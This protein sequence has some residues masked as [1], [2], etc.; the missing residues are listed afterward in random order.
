M[1]RLTLLSAIVLL[2]TAWMFAQTS[3][4]QE[5]TS[6]Q[7]GTTTTQSTSPATGESSSN[8]GPKSFTGCLQGSSGNYSL[9]AT[10]GITYQLQGNQNQ[11][12]KHL[13]QE[14][15]VTGTLPASSPAAVAGGTAGASAG[16]SG[17]P[18]SGGTGATSN[19]ASNQ[20]GR[21]PEMSTTSPASAT[22]NAGIIDVKH[23]SKV[24]NTC[25]TGK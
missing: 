1:R 15:T 22:G 9:V 21:H 16:S 18:S 19:P 20:A 12:G 10:N 25:A 4:S 14:V 5:S 2:T 23:V 3:T 8:P 17:N 11:L 24:S 6:T 7:S 13:D